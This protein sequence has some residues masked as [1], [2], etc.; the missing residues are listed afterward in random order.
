MDNKNALVDLHVHTVASSHAYSTIYE[1]IMEAG[2]KGLKMIGISDHGTELVDGAYHKW[3]FDNLDCV[4]SY[5]DGV[6]ILK[7]IEANIKD[8]GSTDC[9]QSYL[10]HLDYITAGFHGPLYS[11]GGDKAKNTNILIK[12]ISSGTVD[13]ITHPANSRYPLDLERIIE[14]AAA[15]NV[16]LEINSSI[17]SRRGEENEQMAVELIKCAVAHHAPLIIGS[18]AH[19]CFNLG[20]FSLAYRLFERAGCPVDYALNSNPGKVIEF[21][22]SR[23]HKQLQDLMKYC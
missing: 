15:N 9:K 2:R 7:G 18:D 11:A 6:I 1:Y 13:I 8:D 4:P 10:E 17:Y 22:V 16:A 5:R 20:D 3:H 23:S 19:I 14:V 21:L 12:V